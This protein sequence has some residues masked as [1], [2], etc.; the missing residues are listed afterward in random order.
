MKKEQQYKACELPHADSKWPLWLKAF[1]REH[2]NR[3]IQQ[4]DGQKDI[5]ISINVILT[6]RQAIFV[7][8]YVQK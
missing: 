6:W 4:R 8:E 2:Y 7:K 1:K 3:Q 5:E